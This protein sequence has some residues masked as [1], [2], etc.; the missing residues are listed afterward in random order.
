[1]TQFQTPSSSDEYSDAPDN[2]RTASDGM[3]NQD[4]ESQ[5]LTFGSGDIRRPVDI[6]TRENHEQW[7]PRLQ[8]FLIGK[9]IW[10]AVEGNVEGRKG[11]EQ[12]NGMACY[13]IGIC[14]G[15]G[16][17]ALLENHPGSARTQWNA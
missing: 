14:T 17:E 15:E 13:L 5:S 8:N 1:M 7:F 6:L 4:T 11:F 9:G 10:W 3:A 2:Y 12:A 16:D